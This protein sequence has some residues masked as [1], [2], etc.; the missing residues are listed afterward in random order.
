MSDDDKGGLRFSEEFTNS[1][2]QFISVVNISVSVRLSPT[3]ENVSLV[4]L[5]VSLHILKD[6]NAYIFDVCE[7]LDSIFDVNFFESLFTKDRTHAEYFIQKF[8]FFFK[9]GAVRCDILRMG[10][11]N[12]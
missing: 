7:S 2:P 1:Q 11:R 6:M 10:T 4:A 8:S 3:F 5:I 12:K 9:N